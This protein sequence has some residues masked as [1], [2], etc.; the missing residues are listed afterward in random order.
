MAL[1]KIPGNLIETGAITGDVLA[2][3]GIAT[4][5]L[6]N[7]AV[8]TDK[9]L[10]ANITHAKLHTSMD[11]T[12]KTVTVA[13]A[14]GSTNTTAA[15]STAFVQQELT[16]LIGGA[17]GTLD[18]LNEL[19]AAINDDSNYNSTLTTALA[20]K[21]P[22]AGGTL[23]GSLEVN[24]ASAGT[25]VAT[26]EGTY[27]SGGDVQLVRFERGGGAV[28]GAISYKDAT[29]DMEFGTISSH[30]LSLTTGNTRRLTIDNSGNVGMGS[31][32]AA[33]ELIVTSLDN[34]TS[35][36]SNRMLKLIGTSTTDNSRMGIHFTGNTG[37]GNG[38][39]II[40]AVNEDQ[41]AGHTSLRMHTYSGSWNENNLVLKSG[42][43]GIG[44]TPTNFAN[45]KSLDIGFGG[46]IW[47]HTS[48][49][50]TGMG[51]N[52]YFDGAY[53]RT[54]ANAATRHI[55]DGNG[56]TFEV[57]VSGSAGA[58]ISWLNALAIDSSG[59][60]V[61]NSGG[62]DQDFTI[63]SNNSST[64]LYIDGAHDYISF[65]NNA[66][67]LASG[68][69][70]QHG[71][72]IHCLDGY[73]QI[74]ADSTPLT[75]GR[76]S[77]AGRG[78][79]IIMRNASSV[80]GEIGDY[81]G[82]PYIGYTGGAGGGIMFNGS[83]IEPTAIGNART[84]GANDIGSGNYRWRNAHFSNYVQAKSFERI[85][86]FLDLQGLDMGYFYPVSLD[87]GSASVT[88]MFEL[89]KYYGNYNPSVGGVV[90]H[91][92]CS[93]KLDIAGYSWGGN[94]IHNYLHH[95]ASTYRCMV[96]AVTLRG[97]YVPVIWLRG[98]YGY[99]WTSNNPNLTTTL[100]TSNTTFY[101]APYNYT[102]G[103]ITDSVMQGKTGYLGA[104]HKYGIV[105]EDTNCNNWY[106]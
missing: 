71:V 10:D 30:A 26:F 104:T 50:E 89:F 75:T 25:T 59:N 72:G 49:T 61:F 35:F 29:T 85:W 21:L 73:M 34:G 14:A 37:I 36:G 9:I 7:D 38:L 82:V 4:A 45:R 60:T 19:A 41:S 63:K 70:D 103:R 79:H 57:A 33:N 64:A 39:A 99:H 96:G 32:S 100:Y 67:N 78:A 28:Y 105:A 102:I 56:H 20:T 22:L 106:T 90:Q 13:T 5:K 97:Y 98:G 93:L 12:G 46:K 6:A 81:N 55:Q 69:T 88:Q 101:S 11:L 76:T 48:A 68:Y 8:T 15:A 16:T 65:G 92:A 77:T 95:V 80:V 40:E 86:N 91:G 62:V 84:N 74:S 1:T 18:T 43:V 52:F 2:D 58:T 51:S 87:G 27:G 24:N 54:S 23:T 31:A 44:L 53:K 3:G 66:V 42:N 83:S 17:P 94:V 47:G